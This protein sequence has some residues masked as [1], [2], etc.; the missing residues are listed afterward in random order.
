MKKTYL[1][2]CALFITAGLNAQ[3][4]FHKMIKQT[5]ISGYLYRTIQL[6][7]E[8]YAAAGFLTNQELFNDDFFI[9]KFNS[10]GDKEWIKSLSS[11]DSDEFSDLIEA[12]DGGLIAVGTTLSF[13]NFMTHAVIQK[14]NSDGSK[15]WCKSYTVTGKST[16]AK[17]IQ[18]DNEGNLYV[19]GIIELAGFTY[20]YFVM[21]LDANGTILQQASIGTSNSEFALSFLRK[22]NGDLFIGGWGNDGTGESIQVVKLNS[23]LTVQWGKIISGS[24]KYFGYDIKEKSNGNLVIGGRLDDQTTSYDALILELNHSTGDVVWAKQYSANNGLPIYAYGLAVNT[25]DR[26]GIAGIIEDINS[27]T[28]VFET[29]ANGIVNWSKRIN[30]VNEISSLAYG[31]CS[32][33]DEGYVVCGPRTG[34]DSSV[35]QILKVAMTG[36]ALCFNTN[37]P[38]TVTNL[39]LASQNLTFTSAVSNIVAQDDDFGETVYNEIKDA[40]FHTNTNEFL[41]STGMLVFPNPSEGQFSLTLPDLRSGCGIV[42]TD[43]AGRSYYQKENLL[44]KTID[45]DLDL[46][47]GI[48]FIRL[49]SDEGNFVSKLLIR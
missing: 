30:S 35:M 24:I 47:P 33:E 10:E 49:S 15:A 32:T 28:L 22:D 5:G 12:S 31:I 4:V 42:L 25:G 6:S 9:A 37:Y 18:K 36:Y 14:F 20:D 41:P 48:Y 19:L 3:Y 13:D 40:C 2:L 43:A 26:I 27:G 44:D 45:F 23:S 39:T 21:K 11:P 34:I 8:G 1:I 7:D 38:L 17:G 46:M 16:R 29:D